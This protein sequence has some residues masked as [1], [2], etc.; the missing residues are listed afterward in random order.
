MT[1]TERALSLMVVICI[2]VITPGQTV[3]DIANV[4]AINSGESFSGL[5]CDSICHI[6]VELQK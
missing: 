2:Q 3:G 6:M 1:R 4:M 5:E